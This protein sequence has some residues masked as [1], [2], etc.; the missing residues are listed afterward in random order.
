MT[1]VAIF[2]LVAIAMVSLQLFG[3]KMNSFTSSKLKFTGDSLKL[4]SQIRNQIRGAENPVLVGNF[5]TGNNKFTA[6]ANG[7]PAIGNAVQISNGPNSLITFYLNT[8]TFLFYGVDTNGQQTI[9]ARSVINSQ[10]FQAQDYYTNTL[11]AG[12][13]DRYTIKITL[14]FSN[15][16][17]SVPTLS[18]NVYSLK[19]RATPRVQN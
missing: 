17:Y 19:S 8:N 12:S 15:V 10:P 5:N 14:L 7:Q 18:Y 16:N 11:P 9:L 13:S 2:S 3:F 1:T 6:V 4:L